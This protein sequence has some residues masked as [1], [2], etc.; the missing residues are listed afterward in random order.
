MAA[1]LPLALLALLAAAAAASAVSSD[2]GA[3]LVLTDDT[4]NATIAEKGKLFFVEFFAPWCGHC[5]RLSP[6]WKALAASYEDRDD[7]IIAQVDCTSEKKTCSQYEIRGYPSLKMFF[8]G[9]DHE[10]YSGGRDLE[11]LRKYI[12][13]FER[14]PVT[15]VEGNVT[16]LGKEPVLVS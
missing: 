5:K 13:E 2:G 10:K 12:D 15:E 4:F 16:E 3:P 8:D 7:T 11:V 14:I 6:T 1:A 9:K